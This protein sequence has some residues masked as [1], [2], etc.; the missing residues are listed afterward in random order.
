[1]A[2]PSVRDPNT[3]ASMSCASASDLAEVNYML[4]ARK[5]ILAIIFLTLAAVSVSASGRAKQDTSSQVPVTVTVTVLGTHYAAA[6]SI[7][8]DEVTV[9]SGGKVLKV[10]G[11]EHPRPGF[12]NLQLALL[13]DDNVRT[14]LIA[15]QIKDI[16][17]FIE[18][19]A[20][21]TSV[22]LYYA[23][24][25]SAYA[26]SPFTTDHEQ[27][28]KAL[29]LTLGRAGESPSVY[30]SLA[31]LAEH[32]PPNPPNTIFRREVVLFASGNDPLNPGIQ[33]PYFDSSM[34]AVEK[35]GITV[36]AVAIAGTRY[37][38]SFR[39]NVSA[40]KLIQAS[41]PT[42]GQA[43]ADDVA[44]PVS[45]APYLQELNQALKNQ[46]LLT[47]LIDRTKNKKSELREIEVRLE[48]RDIKIS[49]PRQVLV[50]GP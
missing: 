2:F 47:F 1:M 12:P 23:E 44:V 46:Y 42:G 38:L 6:P 41:E 50:P 13:I 15:Q 32:W 18:R 3:N 17:D 14:S 35:A 36:H 11:W 9:H 34:N 49:A 8:Q 33:D 48:Q 24:H 25:G 26:A 27:V 7:P 28:A 29:R 45:I 37:S 43:F 16:A 5:F 20:S 39:G 40:G 30:L 4:S 31:D 22:A 21:T 19:Q 10:T